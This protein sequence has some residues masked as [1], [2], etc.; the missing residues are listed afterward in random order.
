MHAHFA[1]QADKLQGCEFL[2]RFDANY[3]CEWANRAIA[4]VA[5]VAT[6]AGRSVKLAAELERVVSNNQR[7]AQLLA[8]QPLT[9]VHND[10][11]PK[12]VIADRSSSPASIYFVDWEMAGVGCGLLD[13]AHLNHGLDPVNDRKMRQTYREALEEAGAGLLPSDPPELGR[14][15]AACQ[16]HNTLYRLAESS[17]WG[18]PVETVAQWVAEAQ[19]FFQVLSAEC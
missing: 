11:S 1:A 9:L 5:T 17:A 12:N 16:L 13:L 15:F 10:L 14:L 7:V 18:L 4:T 8:E 2:L 6:V 3:F 19:S